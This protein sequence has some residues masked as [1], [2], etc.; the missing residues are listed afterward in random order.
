[1]GLS[2]LVSGILGIPEP[3][4]R[5]LVAL[6]GGYIFAMVYRLL[7]V[8]QHPR[9]K[10][11]FFTLSGIS[12]MAYIY[13]VLVWHSVVDVLAVY[14]V[15]RLWGGTLLSVTITWIITMGHL[16][17][18]YALVVMDNKVHSISWTIPHCV[19]V[20]KLIGLS[21][22]LYDA[23]KP[24]ERQNAVMKKNAVHSLPNLT[25]VTGF[26]YF[27]GSVLAG[28]QLSFVRYTKFIEGR[29]FDWYK[30][31]GSLMTGVQRLLLGVSFSIIYSLLNQYYPISLLASDEFA[32]QS[33]LIKLVWLFIC[34]KLA[35][36]RYIAV[37]LI[38]EGSC[39]VTGITYDGV[40]ESGEANWYGLANVHL[41][42]HE[43]GLTLQAVIDTFN[44]NTNQWVAWYAYSRLKWLGNKM[45]SFAV[46]MLFVSLWHGLWP[47]YFLCFFHELVCVQAERQFIKFAKRVT[48]CETLWDVHVALR[49]P[50]LP[51]VYLVKT[52]AL[53]YPLS[54]FML[55]SWNDCY[56]F[57]KGVYFIG[58][59]V[60]V[61]WILLN[62]LVLQPFV[63]RPH[64]GKGKQE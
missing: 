35:L 31:P 54:L 7:M 38:A 56:K 57:M 16:L 49:L 48:G 41:I 6:Y 36:W 63:F 44:L 15:L 52:F 11:L 20:L 19:L 37:W 55:L 33:P 27:Y 62:Y 29:L 59:V 60:P 2:D 61:G 5:F 13:G 1:M 18:G 17:L 58:H 47:G 14:L 21:F 45:L 10:S 42:K 30:T 25:D 23:R 26:C 64:S 32:N 43:T 51:V 34:G 24:I 3:S 40:D 53:L 50:L 28:P 9:A 12:V 46:T 39:M 8:D 4:A 22:N